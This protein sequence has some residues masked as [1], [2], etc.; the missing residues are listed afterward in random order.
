MR[1]EV[2]EAFFRVRVDGGVGVRRW[3]EQREERVVDVDGEP[4]DGNDVDAQVELDPSLVCWSRI[5]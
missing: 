2:D 3:R 5:K 4:A 1:G